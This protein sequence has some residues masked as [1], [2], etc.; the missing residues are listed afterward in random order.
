MAETPNHEYNVP[1]QGTQDWHNPLNDN[2]ETF[3]VDIELRDSEG[4][5]GNYT[6]ADGAK[7][8]A[9]DTGIV[10]TGDGTTWVPQFV[11]PGYDDSADEVQFGRPIVAPELALGTLRGSL[12]GGTPLTTVV[13]DNL[14]IDNNGQLNAS[15]GGGGGGGIS[16]LSGG[17]GIN[18]ASISDGDTLS[19]AWGDAGEL[20]SDGN[21]TNQNWTTSNN[22]LAPSDSSIGGI[23]V[24]QVETTALTVDGTP[25]LQVEPTGTDFD[26]N[27]TGGNVIGGY[28]D[29]GV[30]NGAVGASIGGG[31]SEGD[32]P[33]NDNSRPNTNEVTGNYGT[34]SGGRN[35]RANQ[36]STV[37]GGVNNTAS[38]GQATVGGGNGN[39]ASGGQAT[40]G[41]GNG[42][43]ANQFYSTVGGGLENTAS[44]NFS[45]VGGGDGN[46][47]SGRQ[48]TVP[49]GFLNTASG[50]RSFAAGSEA[51]AGNE[52]AFVWAD[53]TGSFSSTGPNQFLVNANGGTGIGT[54]SPV[55]TFHVKDSVAESGGDN[56]GRHVAAIENTSNSSNPVPDVLGLELTNVTDPGGFN[57]YISFMDQNGTIGNIQGDGNGGVEFTGTT[58]DFAEFFPKADPD[59]EVEDGTVVGLRDGEVVALAEESDPDA[60]MVVSTAPLMTGNRPIN[61]DER[62]DYVKLSLVGQVPVTVSESVGHGDVLVASPDDDG[63]ALARTDCAESGRPVVGMA[64]SDGESGEKVRTLI[65]GPG[66]DA[67]VAG[68][69]RTATT[70]TDTEQEAQVTRIDKLE[71]DLHE[72]DERIE[73]LEAENEALREETATLSEEN[74][75]LRERLAAVETHLASIDGSGTSPTSADD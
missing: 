46:T 2:F 8:L 53:S 11:F 5:L 39:T 29:N 45:T 70:T 26:N 16:S 22:L 49:G 71:A 52:G 73:D 9:T 24:A 64:L 56:L 42:N 15:T 58:A 3:E 41:G 37:S 31:G 36:G 68:K 51:E 4:N 57:S 62:D 50:D 60:V 38:G 63:T 43:T 12:T 55:T 33:V 66:L 34:I 32:F 74:E 69:S 54:A 30:Q 6:P 28:E 23:D 35:N 13:G 17:D 61:E 19:I 40:V 10:Y 48:A 59:R 47:A 25:T 65:G 14:S 67:T 18:P 72:K 1:Q 44:G 20:D 21:V 27:T 7:F 75:V